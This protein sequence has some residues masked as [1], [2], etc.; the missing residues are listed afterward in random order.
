MKQTHSQSSGPPQT[1]SFTTAGQEPLA[2]TTSPNFRMSEARFRLAF[3]NAPIG[4]AIVGLDYH[5]KRV[6]KALSTAIGYSEKELR[7][8]TFIEITHPDDVYR[9]RELAD[10]L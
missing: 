8:R 7:N 3:E 6:N 10:R 9:D 2:R 4:M 5:I 1:D